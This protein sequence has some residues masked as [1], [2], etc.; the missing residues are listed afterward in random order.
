M[1]VDLGEKATL[2]KS[3]TY[4][5]LKL[6]WLVRCY[7][8]GN[9]FPKGFLKHNEFRSICC[10]VANLLTQNYFMDTMF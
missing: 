9:K 7:L 1:T 10:D 2:E 6:M 8:L 4:I 3:S 5:G